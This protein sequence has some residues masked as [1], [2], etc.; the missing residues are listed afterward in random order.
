MEM[1]L[2][3]TNSKNSP[4]IKYQLFMLHKSMTLTRIKISTEMSQCHDSRRRGFLMSHENDTTRRGMSVKVNFC[5]LENAY[6]FDL[7]IVIIAIRDT[8]RSCNSCPLVAT[9]R[10]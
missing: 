2:N 8:R 7:V 4:N 9:S 6:T 3:V 1:T 5:H 10:I